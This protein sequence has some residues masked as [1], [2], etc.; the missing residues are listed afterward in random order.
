MRQSVDVCTLYTEKVKKL[1][2]KF[3]VYFH[4]AVFLLFLLCL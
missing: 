1:I 4:L 2:Y 3:T